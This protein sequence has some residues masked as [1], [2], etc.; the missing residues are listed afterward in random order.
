[1]G[2][3]KVGRNEN[4]PCGTG[5]KYKRCC[6]A[7]HPDVVEAGAPVPPSSVDMALISQ[8]PAPTF[9]SAVR[10]A[11]GANEKLQ[12]GLSQAEHTA[13][14][15]AEKFCIPSSIPSEQTLMKLEGPATKQLEAVLARIQINYGRRLGTAY[16]DSVR[17][18]ADNRLHQAALS[19]RAYLELS[20]ATAYYLEKLQGLLAKGIESQV[21]LNE[22]HAVARAGDHGGRFDWAAF[23]SGDARA[24][25][26]IQKYAKAKSEK[27]EP[28]TEVEQKSCA[29]F[30]AALEKQMTKVN[31]KA[32]GVTKL[33][34]AALS[35]ICHPSA[36]GDFLFASVPQVPGYIKHLAEPH[37][38]V[39][40]DFI[41]RLALPILVDITQVTTA[42]LVGFQQLADSLREE[43]LPN[44]H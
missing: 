24:T 7:S 20:G 41:R 10:L 4:C 2:A 19:L 29:T 3:T 42:S 31:P 28:R 11:F 25:E 37:P 40:A 22:W 18:I 16:C 9:G 32:A 12:L 15:F 23:F 34:Y 14:Q 43:A 6:G 8:A 5:K 35:D 39:A 38:H 1:M 17:A 27:D 30:V 26:L 36:G 21:Q 44:V 33:V 13:A